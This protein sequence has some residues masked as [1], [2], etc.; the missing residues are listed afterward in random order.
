MRLFSMHGVHVPHRK[1][2]AGLQAVRM[3]V[4]S[5]VKIPLSMHIGAPATAVVAAGDHVDVGQLIGACSGYVS[6][7]VHSSVS[8]TVKGFE[9]ILVANGRTVN[10]VVIETDGLQTPYAECKAP[11][12]TD[13]DSFLA[14]VRDSG[15]VGLGGAGFPTSV[16]L[17]IGDRPLFAV[18]VNGAECEP[19]ITS[20]TRTMIDDREDV[21]EGIRLLRRWLSPQRVIVGIEK[22]K[23]EAIAA[24]RQGAPEGTE[25]RSLPSSYPQGAEKVLIYNTT[26]RVVPEGKL[27]LD[28]GVIVLNVTTLAF[29]ARYMKTGMPL[30][31]K[32]LT[33]DG[34]AVAE[35]KN[36][37]VPIGTAVGEVFAF[38][39]GYS[40]TPGKLLYGGP[41][42]GTA[43]VDETAPVVKNNNALLA[44]SEKDAMLPSSTPCI[45]CGACAEHCPLRLHPQRI[46]HAYKMH[47]L[48]GLAALKVNLCMECGCCS[49]ICPAKRPLVEQNRLAKTE[50]A[51]YLKNKKEEKA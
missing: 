29:L 44:L 3:P 41:M 10:C 51:A 48:E 12:L 1:H 31:E 25:I 19:Y 33:V 8:G 35:P 16:K 18:V 14:A 34:S 28:V 42:M 40:T 4:P 5:S 27:P 13:R 20:D 6:A 37:T 15:A 30:V 11:T 46:A 49:Y 32:T 2:T 43:L 26:G 50:L 22:N 38:C 9:E 47:D 24:M 45:R 36:V 21:F 17:A 39:G 7:P 23:P